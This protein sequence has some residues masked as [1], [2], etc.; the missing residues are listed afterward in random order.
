MANEGN[1]IPFAKGDD[2][3]RQLGRK[4]GSRNRSTIARH[5]LDSSIDTNNPL[6]G[7]EQLMSVEDAITLQQISRAKTGDT[8]AYKAVMDSAYGAPKQAIEHTGEDGG[9]IQTDDLSKLSTDELRR[10]RDAI[11][12]RI[13]DSATSG[14]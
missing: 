5:W 6:T 7:E 2:P 8:N 10:R 1:L 3:R 9:P 14:Q 11:R 4:E 12:G 13:A